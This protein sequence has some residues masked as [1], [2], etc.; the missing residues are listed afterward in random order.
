MILFFY[1]QWMTPLFSLLSWSYKLFLSNISVTCDT[2]L[3]LYHMYHTS[4]FRWCFSIGKHWY[5]VVRSSWR[6]VW[7]IVF[8]DPH[9]VAR[10]QVL[11]LISGNSPITLG[12][13]F[14]KSVLWCSTEVLWLS[15]KKSLDDWPTLW[16]QL[17]TAI[18]RI[19]L[20]SAWFIL[21]DSY[22][23]KKDYC[24]SILFLFF[25]FSQMWRYGGCDPDL[26]VRGGEN[27][28]SVFLNNA[29]HLWGASEHS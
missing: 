6:V 13:K 29:L 7:V 19:W 23:Q 1:M 27:E 12:L 14:T 16:G 15:D 3:D 8:A 18:D 10:V 9:L 11:E 22:V 5:Q 26:S 20:F 4:D 21:I 2:A 25:C 24:P 17:L 28:T